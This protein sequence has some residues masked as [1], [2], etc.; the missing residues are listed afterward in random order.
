MFPSSRARAGGRQFSLRSHLI[1]VILVALLPTMLFA[2]ATVALLVGQ[3]RAAFRRSTAE[4]ARALQQAVDGALRSSIGTLQA[5]ATSRSLHAGDLRTFHAEAARVV[6][7]QSD[8]QSI[9][10]SAPDGRVLFTTLAP[11]LDDPADVI[12]GSR[13]FSAAVESRQPVV[14]DLLTTGASAEAGFNVRVPILRDRDVVYVLS[15]VVTPIFVSRL[16]AEQGLPPEWMAAVLDRNGR[17]VARTG[18]AEEFLGVQ[19]PSELRVALQ[20]T[21][22]GTLKLQS[23]DGVPLQA[24]FS[25]SPLTEWTVALGVPASIVDVSLRRSLAGVTLGSA[26]IL[27]LGMVLAASFSRRIAR[28]IVALS[29]AAQALERGEPVTA[30]P[31]TSIAEVDALAHTLAHASAVRRHAEAMILDSEERFRAIADTAP[32]LIWITGPDGGNVFCNKPWLDFTGRTPEQER[33]EGWREGMHPDDSAAYRDVVASAVAGRQPFVVEYR[34]RRADGTWRWVLDSGVPRLAGDGALT[35]YIGSCIDITD[36]KQVELEQEQLLAR[37]AAAR[38]EA[39]AAAERARFLAE[40]TSLLAS[41]LDYQQTL[42]T[43]ARLAVPRIADMCAVDMVD[44]SGAVDRVALVHVSPAKEAAVREARAR[45]G[46]PS[47]SLVARVL[48]SGEPILRAEMTEADLRETAPEAEHHRV[49]RELGVASAIVAPIAARGRVI[50]ALT[51]HTRDSGRHYTAT[52]LALA[53]DLA[54]RAA[55]AVENARLFGDSEARRREAEALADVAHVLAEGLQPDVVARRVAEKA[56]TLLGAEAACLF[57]REESGLLRAIAVAGDLGPLFV[58]GTE[59]R[60]GA[61]AVGLAVLERCPVATADILADDRLVLTPDMRER[62][63]AARFRSVLAVPFLEEGQVAG[64]FAMADVQGR[65]FTDEEKR[66]AESFGDQAG[67]ALANARLYAAEQAA[68]TQAEALNRSKDEFLAMLGHELRNPLGAIATASQVLTRL[69]D[70][71]PR[72]VRARGIIANQV[73]HLARLVDDLLDVARVA[74]GKIVLDVK[75]LDLGQQVESCASAFMSAGRGAQHRIEVDCASAWV[76]ADATRIDQVTTNLLANAIQ[77]TPADGR[78]R[79]SVARED[80]HAVLRVQDTGVGIGPELLPRVFDLFTQGETA[81]DRTRGGL[82][83]GL[84]LVRR[85]VELHGGTVEAASPGVGR[86]STF[87]VRLPLAPAPMAELESAAGDIGTVIGRRVLVVEDNAAAREMLRVALELEG[88]EVFEAADGPGGLEAAERLQ[89]QVALVDIGLPGLDGYEVAR[90][91][92]ASK[93][94]KR[95]LLIALTGYSQPRDR[96]RSLESGFDAHL[97]KPVDPDQL[98]RLL[99]QASGED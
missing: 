51:L 46:Y 22:E 5:L 6:A 41:A 65:V 76:A 94:G 40:A 69:G 1:A 58:L 27:L 53:T 64:V 23:P 44:A 56:R 54:A 17:L 34:R 70:A 9:S 49:F 61:G 14:G 88:H 39:E 85:L 4:T 26:A 80:A 81:L 48:A 28:P 35:G 7:S 62:V 71:E 38:A 18:S 37:E 67:L 36:R 12:A 66:L 52:D 25:R 42:A 30:P 19:A 95:I 15:A 98:C 92:R 45:F 43:L 75:G 73:R 91:I 57:R 20:S 97:V 63:S 89:P 84:T 10:L 77:Y 21:N 72:A 24:T 8:W 16:L 99:A 60:P 86:G 83:I 74:S 68:R 50:G 32:V 93:G 82:G 87:T 59:I 79:V 90:R 11:P 33:G 55:L 2:A 31:P 29:R 13:A 3:E 47:G 96:D 78:V